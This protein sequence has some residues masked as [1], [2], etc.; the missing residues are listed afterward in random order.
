MDSRNFERKVNDAMMQFGMIGI[1]Y[2]QL[3][4]I[5]YDRYFVHTVE[6]NLV[7]SV[8]RGRGPTQLHMILV[9]CTY[10]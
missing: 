8:F 7:F 2:I 10:S 9:F 6:R 4:V 3:S 1:L 5:W